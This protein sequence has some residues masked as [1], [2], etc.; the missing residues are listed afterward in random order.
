MLSLERRITLVKSGVRFVREDRRSS[1]LIGVSAGWL[2]S[3]GVRMVY[4][5]L[6]PHIR[7]AYALDLAIAGLLITVLWGA[8]ALGQ[9]PAGVL[10]DQ[11]GERWVLAASTLVSAGMLLLVVTAQITVVL[12]VT[13]ALFGLA[14]AMFGVARYTAISK[15]FPERDGTAIGITLAAGNLGNVILPATGG[16]IAAVFAWQLGLGFTIPLFV[17][18]AAYLWVVIPGR[19]TGGER[20]M[21][22]V[23]IVRR[24]VYELRRPAVVIVTGVLILGFSV[25]QAFTGF[26]P[27]YL[28]EVKGL[29]PAVAAGLFSLYFALGIVVQPVAGTVYDWLGIRRT[30]PMFLS[31]TLTGLVLLPFAEGFW[32]IAGVTILL[33]AMMSN[34]AV[35]MPYLTNILPS[36]I[37]GTGLGILRTSYMV[38]G[39]TSPFLF[40]VFADFG[41]FNEGFFVLAGLVIVMIILV[42]Q[43]PSQH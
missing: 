34:I 2:L 18:V 28:I 36:E 25:W 21:L 11:F 24:V 38:L 4:P 31:V 40:G 6:L 33:G 10:T 1:V 35:T 32:Q 19:L 42:L 3:L 27:T 43:L 8:Y 23:D 29:A 22:S 41:Y 7:A 9:L 13:T 37:Q 16:A 5:V 17:I 30:L 20:S 15:V 12:F 39:A 14:T 26:Y